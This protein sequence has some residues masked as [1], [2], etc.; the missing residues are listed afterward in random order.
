MIEVT[1]Q[2]KEIIALKEKLS[3]DGH[4]IE[5]AASR[6]AS[7][8]ADLRSRSK[9]VPDTSPKFTFD[10]FSNLKQILGEKAE[11]VGHAARAGIHSSGEERLLLENVKNNLSA[12]REVALRLKL[13][14]SSLTLGDKIKQLTTP[15]AATS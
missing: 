5:N 15:A 11:I 1:D 7:I 14:D 3:S 4:L 10:Q 9:S 13:P 2:D 8:V 12:L 6:I